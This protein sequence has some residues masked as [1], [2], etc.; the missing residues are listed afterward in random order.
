MKKKSIIF[1]FIILSIKLFITDA[2]AEKYYISPWAKKEV[3]IAK[4]RGYLIDEIKYNLTGYITKN[5]LIKLVIT[6]IEKDIRIGNNLREIPNYKDIK[7]DDKRYFDF[8]SSAIDLDIANGKTQKKF[9]GYQYISRKEALLMLSRVKKFYITK[10]D[11]K[12]NKAYKDYLN[13]DTH[14]YLN[15]WAREACEFFIKADIIKGNGEYYNFDYFF[16]AEEAI[17]IVNRYLDFLK[18]APHQ[19]FTPDEKAQIKL[20]KD[21]EKENKIH[22]TGE[23]YKELPIISKKPYSIGKTSD[24]QLSSALNLV[25]HIRTILSLPK[26][27]MDYRLNDIAQTTSMYMAISGQFSH[28]LKKDANLENFY[29]TAQKG[30]SSSNIG[31]GYSSIA[32]FNK[33]CLYDYDEENIADLGHRR[34]LINPYLERIGFGL[35]AGY[36]SSYVLDENAK[37]SID[38]D[39]LAYPSKAFPLEYL[40]DSAWSIQLNLKDKYLIKKDKEPTVTLKRINDGK[41]ILFNTVSDK[42]YINKRYYNI[43]YSN[44]GYG[45]AIIFKPEFSPKR[46][47][48]FE[49][50]V[51]NIFDK[52]TGQEV[53]L[54]Y[55]TILY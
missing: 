20:A 41:I 52:K 54:K 40:K 4:N 1:L 10:H 42:A 55:N 45:P 6:A 11:L 31:L 9:G 15:D 17:T 8:I 3:E 38:I 14:K 33:Y 7:K 26:V 34:W 22:Y 19:S 24:I 49:I 50:I 30:A 29:D 16:T 28:F 47:D 23:H 21:F 51:K 48:R 46:M 5:N 43:S 2:H 37:N 44:S 32:N 12:E 18:S 39:Y 53:L 35:V 13:T 36:A 25:N 27:E